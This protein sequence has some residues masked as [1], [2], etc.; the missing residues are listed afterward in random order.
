MVIRISQSADGN[1]RHYL[2][3]YRVDGEMPVGFVLSIFRTANNRFSMFFTTRNFVQRDP[4]IGNVNVVE[5]FSNK[6][7]RHNT[8]S[9]D[10]HMDL[11]DLCG[12]SY[13][14]KIVVDNYDMQ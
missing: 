6:G 1:H 11:V 4:S 2:V 14:V 12:I 13:A 8:H 9:I 10:D 3:M 5:E 7:F